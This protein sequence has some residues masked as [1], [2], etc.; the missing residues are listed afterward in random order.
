MGG[1]LQ[2]KTYYDCD[3]GHPLYKKVY[4]YDTYHVDNHL[5]NVPIIHNAQEAYY[6]YDISSPYI[7]EMECYTYGQDSTVILSTT[8]RDSVDMEGRLRGQFTINSKGSTIKHEY[9][10]FSEVPSYLSSHIIS[11]DNHITSALKYT[12]KTQELGIY[13]PAPIER[14]AITPTSTKTNLQYF[15]QQIF[16]E[17]N[18]YCRPLQI[19]DKT[20]KKTCI[21][22]GYGGM[23]PVARV[24]NISYDVFWGIYRVAF[25][26]SGAL[27]TDVDTELRTLDE[28]ILVTTYTYKPLVGLTS[29]TDPTGHSIYC[30]YDD[31][32]RLKKIRDDAGSIIKSYE[33]NII[34]ENQ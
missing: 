13:V 31:N 23:Y 20:G 9:D 26:Y 33:Y 32:G 18:A 19:T 5:I 22:W 21:L 28:N 2:S 17:Y 14:A 8:Q 3:F 10:Y 27:P 6:E 16:S 34:S 25:Q 4:M 24:E 29:V 30:E 1:K 11:S 15:P 12:Y 7:Q